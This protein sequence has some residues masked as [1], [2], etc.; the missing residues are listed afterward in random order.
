VKTTR[1]IAKRKIL[2]KLPPFSPIGFDDYLGF[3][4]I[5]KNKKYFKSKSNQI[6]NN[7]STHHEYWLT[8][9]N[10]SVL[11]RARQRYGVSRWNFF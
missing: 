3:D 4:Q 6:L 5:M 10:F 8:P 1:N 7:Y 2:S 11:T 9:A